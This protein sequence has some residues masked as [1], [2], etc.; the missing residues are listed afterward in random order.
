MY[1]RNV[2]R[3]Q[4]ESWESRVLEVSPDRVRYRK[5]KTCYAWFRFWTKIK[6]SEI[7]KVELVET[8]IFNTKFTITTRGRQ[9]EFEA[10]AHY[11]VGSGHYSKVQE[12][13]AKINSH[14]LGHDIKQVQAQPDPA[15]SD[16][17]IIV[18]DGYQNTGKSWLREYLEE[19]HKGAIDVF[20]MDELNISL[21]RGVYNVEQEMLDRVQTKENIRKKVK[22]STS[23]VVVFTGISHYIAGRGK[24]SKTHS[25]FEELPNVKHIWYEVPSEAVISR[26]WIQ[27][28]SLPLE[29]K[30]LIKDAIEV[31]IRSEMTKTMPHRDEAIAKAQRFL[32]VS[33]DGMRAVLEGLLPQDKVAT[34][35]ED[36]YSHVSMWWFNLQYRKKRTIEDHL[37]HKYSFFGD[38]EVVK[39]R[40]IHLDQAGILELVLDAVSNS[41]TPKVAQ[42][43]SC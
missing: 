12:L 10:E 5:F 36:W 4:K 30:M 35:S 18:I 8:S 38:P 26:S 11:N 28:R 16:K 15:K 25:Y 1:E 2:K 14:K 19:K 39:A 43:L 6:Y 42:Q 33:N 22:A 34:L 27:Y 7:L 32:N 41:R 40:L 21:R 9:Y 13:V 17:I 37:D 20:E 3:E 24:H 29:D 23:K 31:F